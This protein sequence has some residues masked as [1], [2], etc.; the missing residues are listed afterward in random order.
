MTG[1]G[2]SLIDKDYKLPELYYFYHYSCYVHHYYTV[3]TRAVCLSVNEIN[4]NKIHE[5]QT[6][7]SIQENLRQVLPCA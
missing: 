7:H 1:T 6:Q 4:L 5:I 2:L 3:F